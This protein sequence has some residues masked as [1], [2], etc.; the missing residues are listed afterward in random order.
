MAYEETASLSENVYYL[1]EYPL[2][3]NVRKPE[4]DNTEVFVV[5]CHEPGSAEVF[6]METG[7]TVDE[8][9]DRAANALEEHSA[10]GNE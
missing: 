9:M 10:G 1:I 4:Q 3:I 2:D 7:R 8:A 6:I 5:T